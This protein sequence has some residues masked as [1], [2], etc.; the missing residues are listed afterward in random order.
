M[1][2]E[3]KRFDPARLPQIP[4]FVGTISDEPCVSLVGMAGAGKSTLGRMVAAM[5]GFAHMDTDRLI[6]ATWGMPL[7]ALLDAKGL[8][9]F[10][11]IEEDVVS[12]LWLKRCVISTGGSVVYGPRAVER[13]RCCGPVVF[14]RIDL[15]TFLARVGAAE[16][17][18]FARPGGKS[19][20]EVFAER[21]PLYAAISDHQTATDGM[22]PED[23]A[24]DI[25]S[26]ARPR[27][28]HEEKDTA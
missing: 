4:P 14:L 10:L 26:W 1:G 9:E 11:R 23:C 7:Q 22:S 5:L 24:R 16:D 6:E 20:A 3:D 19:L 25:V 27:L 15:A 13:L 21:Q 2:G 17:R 8:T 18:G 12:R 28:G